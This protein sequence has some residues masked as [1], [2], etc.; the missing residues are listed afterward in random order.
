MRFEYLAQA[1]LV[2]IGVIHV[3]P[4]IVACTP[5]RAVAVY[6]TDLGNRDQELLLRHRALLLALVGAGVI[7][8]AFVAPIRVAAIIAAAI[9]MSSFVAL[10]LTVGFRE[11]N[12]KAKRVAW[13]DVF[14]LVG[15]A[16]AAL[17]F[18]E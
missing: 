17:A 7:V 18:I 15:L 5:R 11:L 16:I 13:V 1:V 8:G 10:A 6:G 3:V 2:L 14:A 9:S 4:G 12:E